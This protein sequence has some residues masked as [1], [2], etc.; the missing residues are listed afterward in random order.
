[1]ATVRISDLPPATELDGTEIMPIVQSGVTR[2][3]VV[4]IGGAG[5]EGPPGPKGDQGDPGPQGPEGPAGA[6]GST[7]F[8]PFDANGSASASR[9]SVPTSTTV[10]W[11]NVPSQ[12]SNLGPYDLWEA[13]N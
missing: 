2:R 1:M 7:T 5:Q 3:M 12:P 4:N 9:P 6:D 8:Y 13:P 10:M 11:F